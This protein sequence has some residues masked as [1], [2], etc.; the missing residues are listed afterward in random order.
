[1]GERGTEAEVLPIDDSRAD[2]V[3]IPGKP[4]A[5]PKPHRQASTLRLVA[6]VLG[7]RLRLVL[8][9]FLAL[10]VVGTVI[11]ALVN[12]EGLGQAAYSAIITELS[13]NVDPVDNVTARVVLIVLTLVSIALIP[14][15]TA[16]VVDSIVKARLR[17][18]SGGLLGPISKHIV[19]IGLGD[20]GTRV[21][22]ALHDEGIDIVAVERDPTAR[23]V[24]VARELEVPVIIA[25]GSRAATLTAASVATCRALIVA[26]TD[27]V[28]NLETALL[29]RAAQPELRVVL[30]LFDGEFADR[31]R[32]AFGI[33][34][35]RSVSYLAAPAFAAAMLGR[36]V[37]ATIPVRRRALVVAE[38][39]IGANSELEHQ[40]A[41]AVN[42][43]HAARLLAIRTGDGAQILWRPSDARPLRSTDK[44]LVVATRAGLASVMARTA[45]PV[46]PGE[47]VP[48][49]L[50][51]PWQ[52]PQS[53]SS[54]PEGPDEHP[55]FG[56]ADAGSTRP[57]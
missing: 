8:A 48:Y 11:L 49:R 14:A 16:T 55:P 28:V 26:S 25:D 56:P 42:E 35:S 33:N 3:L 29:G 53:R 45:S 22:R 39:P 21:L 52:M 37:I 41:A 1:M 54:W 31:V 30:R 24:Q 38:L 4:A 44:I 20:V 7:P 40:G 34:I 13:G 43:D 6:I 15:L 9:V 47:A 57:A 18:D 36:Q 46:D 2:L 32:H 19:V 50:L 12:R 10:F 23:G 51:E 17:R 27:D 5:P